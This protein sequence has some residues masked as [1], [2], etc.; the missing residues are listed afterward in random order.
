MEDP[1]SIE[2]FSETSRLVADRQIR[3]AQR[4]SRSSRTYSETEPHTLINRNRGDSGTYTSF[5]NVPT[6]S[7]RPTDRTIYEGSCF[8]DPRSFFHR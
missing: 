5:Q 1:D 2:S 8:C 7:P 4:A 3:R 6:A